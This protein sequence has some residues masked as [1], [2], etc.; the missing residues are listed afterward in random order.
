V[1]SRI[2]FFNDQYRDSAKGTY[3]AATAKGF[4]QGDMMNSKGVVLGVNANTIGASNWHASAQ[5]Q[6]VNYTSCHDNHTLWD[7]LCNSV[8]GEV[9]GANYYRNREDSLV[10]LN[11]LAAAM[12][13]SCQGMAFVLAGEEMARSKDGDHNSYK[14]AATKNMID[15]NNVSSY[16]DLVS[17]YKGMIEIRKAF[18]P[19]TY[20]EKNPEMG[21]YFN[22]A[23]NTPTNVIAYTVKN[24]TKGEWQKMAVVYNSAQTEKEVTL[25]DTTLSDDCKW[26]IIAN[27]E[28]AG[29]K[30]LG[31]ITG[32][33][34]TV[35]ASSALIM[36]DKESFENSSVKPTTSVV[37]VKHVLESTGEV[38][39]TRTIRGTIGSK[40]VT[41]A[42]ADISQGHEV[43]RIA[44]DKKGLYTKYDKEVTYYY[45][46]YIP[47][48]LT[49]NDLNGDGKVNIKDATLVQKYLSGITGIDYDKEK[50][51]YNIDSNIDIKDVTLLQKYLAK[52]E[53]NGTST[54]TVNYIYT[55]PDT[56][57][58]TIVAGK[59]TI[60]G[61]IGSSYEV[62]P[63]KV[64]GY[65][66]DETALP[67]N[68]YGV[69][70][71]EDKEITFKY[72]SDM[73]TYNLRFKHSGSLSWAPT[74]WP[75]YESSSGADV[76][77]YVSWPGLNLSQKD[78][79]GWYVASLTVPNGCPLSLIVSKKGDYQTK[80]Y[81][82]MMNDGTDY[83]IVIDDN[84]YVSQS[85]DYL[86]FYTQNPEKP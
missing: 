68:A 53:I 56:G 26:V 62:N 22:N 86:K 82:N 30:S 55:N 6:C 66:C 78:E 74:I 34:F 79:D 67:D 16:D 72:L 44:G 37:R 85:N 77:L 40:Y 8:Y 28:T 17:Y 47:A 71:F 83:W 54:L 32:K 31:E 23:V 45:K 18:T 48:T 24:P 42:D 38:L 1:D 60:V 9:S 20:P 4:V 69:F 84:L 61:R 51:D 2:G 57:V 39:K 19:F 14:S 33:T 46:K 65:I 13:F 59:I 70:G 15:W 3:S 11:K 80:D 36:V 27:G 76:D 49:D 35:P 43:T 58:E 52:F 81:D 73:L 12:T 7:R 63:A 75:W 50:M 21:Y 41:T 64:D 10:G 29:T 5:T 25:K